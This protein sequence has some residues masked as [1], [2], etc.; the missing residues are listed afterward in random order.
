MLFMDERLDKNGRENGMD[1]ER[2]E[3]RNSNPPISCQPTRTLYQTCTI[4]NGG[5]GLGSI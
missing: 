4:L 3:I 5:G 1:L 2:F